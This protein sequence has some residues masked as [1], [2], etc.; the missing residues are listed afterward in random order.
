MTRKRRRFTGISR[1][2]WRWRRCGSATPWSERPLRVHYVVHQQDRCLP[3]STFN[4]KSVVEIIALVESVPLHW[5]GALSFTLA[6]AN[7]K[8]SESASA[9]RRAKSGTNVG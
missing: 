4:G 9:S 6:T 8:G 7:T 1:S 2:G 5:G 3:D